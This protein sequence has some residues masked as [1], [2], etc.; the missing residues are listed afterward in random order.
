LRTQACERSWREGKFFR[1][2]LQSHRGARGICFLFVPA[3]IET[4]KPSP[5]V[6]FEFVLGAKIGKCYNNRLLL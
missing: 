6:D 1:G 4:M 3:V 5:S 2:L